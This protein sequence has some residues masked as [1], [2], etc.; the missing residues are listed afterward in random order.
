MPQLDNAP[1]RDSLLTFIRKSI[2]KQFVIPVYQRNYTWTAK[3]EVEKC[4]SILNQFYMVE[5]VPI[6]WVS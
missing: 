3:R 6:L 1:T 4:L 5:K 2:N